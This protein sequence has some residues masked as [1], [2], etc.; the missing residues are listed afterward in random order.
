[1]RNIQLILHL[2]QRWIAW[3]FTSTVLHCFRTKFTCIRSEVCTAVKIHFVVF[4]LK[5]HEDGSNM[6]LRNVSSAYETVRRHD[7][8]GYSLKFTLILYS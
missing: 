6:F 5:T 4:C 7:Q 8:E 2:C 1:M 3:R